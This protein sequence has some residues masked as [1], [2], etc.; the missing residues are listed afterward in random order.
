LDANQN[1]EQKTRPRSKAA[2]KSVRPRLKNPFFA[3]QEIR[4]RAERDCKRVGEQIVHVALADHHSHKGQ[5]A[6]D[7]HCSSSHIE[8][9]EPEQRT[10]PVSIYEARLGG[11]KVDFI[12]PDSINPNSINP[13]ELFVPYEVV[14]HR[15][16]DCY[17]GCRKVIEV[18]S[19]IQQK[20]RGDLHHDAN[21]AY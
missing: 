10:A 2:G 9:Q 21:S 13:G 18:Q 8:A 5:V 3:D 14:S 7:R 6:E 17:R 12:N 15:G 11:V 1:Q 16:F 4:Q 20:K 19:S